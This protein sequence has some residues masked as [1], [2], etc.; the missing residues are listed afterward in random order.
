MS[1]VLGPVNRI[2]QA[3]PRAMSTT[4]YTQRP[5]G[6]SHTSPTLSHISIILPCYRSREN[7]DERTSYVRLVIIEPGVYRDKPTGA[8]LLVL[9]M[10]RLGPMEDGSDPNFL[11]MVDVVVLSSGDEPFEWER[12]G[13]LIQCMEDIFDDSH[14]VN[15]KIVPGICL[16]RIV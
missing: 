15:G 16:E 11:D 9:G 6:S 13:I 1:F 4:R 3:Y 12:E 10:T 5:C 14:R 7:S 8:I 2:A